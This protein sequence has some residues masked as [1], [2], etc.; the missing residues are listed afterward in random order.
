MRNCT[1]DYFTK[2]KV[3]LEVMVIFGVAAREALSFLK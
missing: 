1:V 3:I 2:A